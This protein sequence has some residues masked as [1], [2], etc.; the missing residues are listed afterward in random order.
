MNL[1]IEQGLKGNYNY[2]LFLPVL[3]LSSASLILFQTSCIQVFSY[4]QWYHFAFWVISMAMLGFG[5]AGLAVTLGL[6]RIRHHILKAVFW[7]L[8]LGSAGICF[9]SA[10]FYRGWIRFDSF[11]I[12]TGWTEIA[13]L[14]LTAFIFFIPFFLAATA[15]GIIFSMHTFNIGRL[16]AADLIGSA[17]GALL[18]LFI[19]WNLNPEQLCLISSLLMLSSSIIVGRNIKSAIKYIALL[20]SPLSIIILWLIPGK[21]HHSEYKALSRALLLPDVRTVSENHSPFGTVQV[22]SSPAFRYGPGLS[23]DF[24]GEIPLVSNVYLNGDYAGVLFSGSA[25]KIKNMFDATVFS[26][27][28]DSVDYNNVLVAKAGTGEFLVQSILLN[29]RSTD[30][31]EQNPVLARHAQEH[32]RRFFKN[33]SSISAKIHN[34]SLRPFIAKTSKKYDL[35]MIP[36]AGVF[37]GGAGIKAFSQDEVLTTQTVRLLFD[38]LEKSGSLCLSAW[39]DYPPRTTPR[40][41]N[42]LNEALDGLDF[43]LIIIRNWSVTM[44]LC[45]KHEKSNLRTEHIVRKAEELSFEIVYPILRIDTNESDPDLELLRT[46][47]H[48]AENSNDHESIA[49]NYPF[50]ITAPTDDNPYFYQF[51]K[52]KSVKILRELYGTRALPF[53]E[54]G[55]AI[56]LITLVQLLVF[57]TLLVLAPIII[58]GKRLR[59]GRVFAFLYFASIGMAYMLFEIMLIGKLGPYLG[60]TV[61]STAIVLACLLLFSGIGSRISEA[62]IFSF[63]KLW[64]PG[65]ACGI[66]IILFPSLLDAIIKSTYGF[67]LALKILSVSLLISI[68]AVLMGF[69]FPSGMIEIRGKGEYLVPWSWCVNGAFSVSG[70][71]LATILCVES[72]YAITS[73]LSGITYFLLALLIILYSKSK[74]KS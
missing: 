51:L 30:A 59:N 17:T 23:T 52:W 55:Y 3:F 62:G 63:G 56:V 1:E 32:A 2:R 65:I 39:N 9:A 31:V 67:S 72:G 12:F 24:T 60:N 45:Q 69:F 4:L 11:L 50:H 5:A 64:I 44:I 47:A 33:N 35:I 28:Y 41:V 40:L 15:I 20:I 21:P 74:I 73:Q 53:I 49:D 70:A 66:C 42:L 7:L 8:C 36:P 43:N 58:M 54:I 37:G 13:S 18:V 48:Q 57:S 46:L 29:S 22:L 14:I 19:S 6:K 25:Q 38:L 16:Y 27:A 71:A 34:E 61:Y 68:P 10:A 26:L